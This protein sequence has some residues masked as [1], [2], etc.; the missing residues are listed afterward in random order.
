MQIPRSARD[1]NS[2]KLMTDSPKSAEE[3]TLPGSCLASTCTF[4]CKFCNY[5]ATALV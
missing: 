4:D 3:A 2:L 5:P 1:D